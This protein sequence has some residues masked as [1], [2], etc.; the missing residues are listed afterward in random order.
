MNTIENKRERK[1]FPNNVKC[2]M[3]TECLK[4]SHFSFL[5]HS[6]HQFIKYYDRKTKDE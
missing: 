1:Y 5:L 3:C 6:T 4:I 2:Q